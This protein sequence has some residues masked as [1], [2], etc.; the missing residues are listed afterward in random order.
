M[1]Q[2]NATLFRSLLTAGLLLTTFSHAAAQ[3]TPPVTE[4]RTAAP[5][6][7]TETGALNALLNEVHLLRLALQTTNT[8][9]K[10]IQLAAERIRLQQERVDKV[11]RELEETRNQITLI[12]ADQKRLDEASKELEKQARQESFPARRAEIEKQMRILRVDLEPLSI[13]ETRLKDRESQLMA[14]LSFEQAKLNE[15][16]GKL[17][18][19]EREFDAAAALERPVPVERKKR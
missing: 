17:D 1:T 10:R 5:L 9:A 4:P 19:L 3:E 6:S 8:G 11:S 14:Q 12:N 7:S 18:E 16:N 13:R 15:L 2:F